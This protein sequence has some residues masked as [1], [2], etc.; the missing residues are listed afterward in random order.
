MPDEKTL[1]AMDM[2]T[3]LAV[4]QL[5]KESNKNP[6]SVLLDFMQSDTAKMAY[7]DETKLWWDGPA[8]TAESFKEETQKKS[9]IDVW[10]PVSLG[11][12]KENASDWISKDYQNEII[13]N[14]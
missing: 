11:G 13:D 8:C 4:E 12:L 10:Q 3:M 6:E 9:S 2:N 5:A 14:K 1:F 7:D